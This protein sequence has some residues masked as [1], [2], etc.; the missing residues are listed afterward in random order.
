MHRARLKNGDE[1]VVKVQRPD[2]KKKVETDLSIMREIATRG[3]KFFEKNGIINVIDVVDAFDRSMQK[4]LDY[5]SEARNKL[6]PFPPSETELANALGKLMHDLK[7]SVP[8]EVWDQVNSD[9]PV[10]IRQLL[11]ELLAIC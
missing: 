1:V 7:N 2:V 6:Q 11:R 10:N 8:K 9:M 3:N 5:N 4:E